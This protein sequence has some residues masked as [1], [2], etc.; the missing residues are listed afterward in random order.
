V[1][2]ATTTDTAGD[3]GCLMVASIFTPIQ[4]GSAT[5]YANLCRFAPPGKMVALATRRH[6]QDGIEIPG[7]KEHDARCGFPIHRLDLLR[8]EMAPP[9]ANKLVS[10]W[11]YLTIDIPLRLKIVATVRRLIREHG[12]GVICIGELVSTAWLG[13]FCR[14]F[15]GVRMVLYVHGEEITQRLG[16]GSFGR[17]RGEHLRGAD[18]V[19]AVS[20][21]T[22]QAL[23]EQMGVRPERI[24]LIE[25]GVDTWR[26]SPGP[27]DGALRAS[28]PG[29]QAAG[30]RR[31][32]AGAPQGLRQ[33]H[34][35]LGAGASAH[36]D[37]HLLIIGDGPQRAELQAMADASPAAARSPRGG[38]RRC[39]A[40]RGLPQRQ[41]VRDAQPHHARWGYRRFRAGLPRSQRLRS[42]GHRWAGRR[43]RRGGA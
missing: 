30:G 31:R 32:P 7:W 18:A 43:R 12:I 13:E 17:R 42:G 5:V 26:F 14:R 38:A 19:V 1:S 22:R 35:R 27:D 6:Y 25:N 23:I 4:G 40:A 33:D 2:A 3:K 24:C 15:F 16:A 10:A 34:R 28:G 41:P 20:R 29:R 8:P 39:R 21:F 9:P 11:R 37:A 36:P